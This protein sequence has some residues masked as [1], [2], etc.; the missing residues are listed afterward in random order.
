MAQKAVV[1]CNGSVNTKFLY[2]NISKKDFLIAVDGGANKLVKTSFKPNII[3]GDMDSI[4]KNAL[5]KFKAS[6][7]IR[8]PREKDKIDLELAIDYCVKKKF[9]EIIILGALGTRADMTMT[10]IFLLTQ[11]PKKID[12]RII[13]ENQEIY[14]IHKKKSSVIG[15]PREQISLFPINGNVK[16]LTLEGF[17]YE[18]K[19]Y[20]LRFGIGIGLSNEFKNKKAS[21]T[22]KDGLLLCVHFRKW[23]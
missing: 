4:S 2:S 22:F 5:K 17:K 21:I 1:V 10:N 15:L 13:H 6:E 11:I 23:F 14:L 18:I 3:I 12:A 8:Y 20:N 19:N 16:G 7:Q 9:K